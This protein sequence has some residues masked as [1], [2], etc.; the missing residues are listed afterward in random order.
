MNN[1]H[2]APQGQEPQNES[3]LANF[4]REQLMLCANNYHHFVLEVIPQLDLNCNQESMLEIYRWI[5]YY[6]QIFRQFSEEG[7]I[8]AATYVRTSSHLE[9]TIRRILGLPEVPQNQG[10]RSL[11]SDFS[12][13]F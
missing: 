11:F 5:K 3:I 8:L 12:E 2:H 10:L 9:E 1:F 4:L 7:D 13:E 6:Q